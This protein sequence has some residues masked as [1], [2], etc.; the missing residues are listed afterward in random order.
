MEE[1]IMAKLSFKRSLMGIMT[2]PVLKDFFDTISQEDRPNIPVYCIRLQKLGNA[3]FQKFGIEIAKKLT[4]EEILISL[5]PILATKSSYSQKVRDLS[6]V[7][8]N[9]NLIQRI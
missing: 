6:G 8:L 9:K 2:C 1:K 4:E 3:E 5:V 7:L